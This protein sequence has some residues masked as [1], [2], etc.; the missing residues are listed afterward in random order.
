MQLRITLYLEG[1][2]RHDGLKDSRFASEWPTNI[3]VNRR[4]YVTC[5]F[6]QSESMVLITGLDCHAKSVV[7]VESWKETI[8]GIPMRLPARHA[9]PEM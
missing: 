9:P 2:S 6:N 3:S 7:K 1:L 4:T 5:H 8:T